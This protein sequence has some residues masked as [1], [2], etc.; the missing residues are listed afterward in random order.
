MNKRQ[1]KKFFKKKVGWNPPSTLHYSRLDYHVLTKKPWGGMT[2]LKRQI[3]I[4]SVE[5]F[6]LHIQDRN[7]QIKEMRRYTR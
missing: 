5:G 6:N 3:K 1:K 4:R 7:N 2:E